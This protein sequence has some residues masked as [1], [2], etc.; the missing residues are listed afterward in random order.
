MTATRTRH[1]A[2]VAFPR[3]QV[4]DVTGPLEVF[5]QAARHLQAA[6]A[7]TAPAYTT[8]IVARRAGPVPMSS[9]VRLVADRS[10]GSRSITPGTP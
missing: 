4:L 1:V 8:E 7:R 2:L 10:I 3:A 5:S 9:G 6:N